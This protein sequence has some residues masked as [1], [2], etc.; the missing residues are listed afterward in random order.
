MIVKKFVSKIMKMWV[1][2]RLQTRD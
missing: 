1:H 2:R